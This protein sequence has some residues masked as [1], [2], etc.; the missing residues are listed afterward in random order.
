MPRLAGYAPVVA[1]GGILHLGLEE[2]GGDCPGLEALRLA[3]PLVVVGGA[4][5]LC[6]SRGGQARGGGGGG[7]QK[8]D[9]RG[10]TRGRGR[11]SGEEE[12]R[13]DW[14]RLVVKKTLMSGPH[15]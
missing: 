2:A 9:G 4:P 10:E 8:E 1:G 5:R 12:G 3:T 6:S 14:G 13:G 11:G 15:I 7:E